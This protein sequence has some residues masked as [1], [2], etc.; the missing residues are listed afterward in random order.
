MKFVSRVACLILLLNIFLSGKKILTI[1]G[2]FKKPTLVKVERSK[3]FI[4]DR[5]NSVVHVYSLDNVKEHKTICS[6]GEGPGECRS[7]NSM[8]L[9]NEKVV[10]SGEE[11]LLY[12]DLK[13]RL[14]DERKVPYAHT[15]VIP[16]GGKYVCREYE[17]RRGKTMISAVILD[18]DFSSAKKLDQLIIKRP[19]RGKN[20]KRNLHLLDHYFKHDIIGQHI[21][22]GNTQKAFH[23]GIFDQKGKKL[24]DLTESIKNAPLQ[25]AKKRPT[26]NK[27]RLNSAPL[28][29]GSYRGKQT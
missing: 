23:F 28:C 5:P 22:V 15:R 12:F 29:S 4:I 19:Y 14:L 26:W 27:S 8:S 7:L 25:K 2:Q 13:G 11:K 20:G 18:S 17:T 10:I 1:D 21:I 24:Y 9:Q 16:L 6:R 3:V